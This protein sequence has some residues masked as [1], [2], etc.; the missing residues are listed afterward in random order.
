MSKKKRQQSAQTASKGRLVVDDDAYRPFE[1]VKLV[2]KP[3]KQELPKHREPNQKKEPLVG[4][5]D[6][7]ADFGEI[8]KA[9]ESGEDPSK[10]KG[11]LKHPSTVDDK[12]DF[13]DIFSEWEQ[14]HDPHSQQKQPKKPQPTAQSKPYRQTKDFGDILSQFEGKPRQ[15]PNVA[16]P[17][18]PQ[19]K[20]DVVLRESTIT[21]S[22]KSFGELLD[23]YE[24]KPKPMTVA[25]APKETVVEEE[26]PIQIAE[27]E[28]PAKVAWK[29][30]VSPTGA[31]KGSFQESYQHPE[32]EMAPQEE[33]QEIPLFNPSEVKLSGKDFGE[34]L[35]GFEEG[36]DE[37]SSSFAEI[38]KNW[39]KSV[40]EEKAIETSKDVKRERDKTQYTISELRAMQPQVTLD[41]H[42]YKA[43]EAAQAARKF[44]Q[45]SF[46]HHLLKICL[47]PGKGIH[48]EDGNGV[49]KEVVLSEVRLSGVVREAYSPKACFG[50]SGV[51]WVILKDS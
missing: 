40:N 28:E 31:S 7:D 10:V 4:G 23:Q 20:K 16:K 5:F 12:R 14:Q 45:D 33:D 43:D 11:N 30:E 6:R 8:L 51:I 13:A 1:G 3:Q 22:G 44:L 17:Q 25:K 18:K 15:Q 39:S 46:Q 2:E 34:I 26:Q 42:G 24:G 9:W 32:T 29:V 41:L 47:I 27:P 36:K 37:P 38:Y 50:G 49:L 48:S 19:P 35:N 21:P